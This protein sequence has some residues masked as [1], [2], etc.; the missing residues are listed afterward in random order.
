MD[1]TLLCDIDKK[2]IDS[3]VKTVGYIRKIEEDYFTI[4]SYHNHERHYQTNLKCTYCKSVE[5]EL[6][7]YAVVK[8]KLKLSDELYICSDE[9]TIITDQKAYEYGVITNVHVPKPNNTD[10][11]FQ[12]DVLSK[13][14]MDTAEQMIQ[15]LNE[16]AHA[17]GFQ[18]VHKES[19]SKS[20]IKLRCHLHSKNG[21]KKKLILIANFL[22]QYL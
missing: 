12:K 21:K 3:I 5:I 2:P 4:F 18:F 9:V 11:Y 1:L 10:T 8:G 19:L 16:K 15:F 17:E 20:Y 22:L 14:K 7:Q 6:G 13:L